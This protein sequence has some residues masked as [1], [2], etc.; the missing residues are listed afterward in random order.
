MKGDY[1]L[2]PLAYGF[3]HRGV[4]LVDLIEAPLDKHVVKG[5]YYGIGFINL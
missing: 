2:K 3:H 1:I 4:R 5:R